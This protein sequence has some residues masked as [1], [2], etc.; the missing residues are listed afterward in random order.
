MDGWKVPTY[1]NPPN[2][3]NFPSSYI[4][5]PKQ[6]QMRMY[7]TEKKLVVRKVGAEKPTLMSIMV[8]KTVFM[9]L[10]PQIVMCTVVTLTPLNIMHSADPTKG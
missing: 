8:K 5:K 4:C 7:R 10:P 3:S 9:F 1:I 6:Q 2:L